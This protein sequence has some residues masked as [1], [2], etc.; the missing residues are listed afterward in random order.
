MSWILGPGLGV[1]EN[2]R[3]GRD[4]EIRDGRQKDGEK[5]ITGLAFSA[6]LLPETMSA[7]PLL[8]TC[9]ET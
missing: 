5:V 8:A 7:S 9:H 1:R 6:S 2:E 3:E 4:G